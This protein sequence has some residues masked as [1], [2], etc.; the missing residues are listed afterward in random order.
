MNKRFCF[1]CNC[2]SCRREKDRIFGEF[3]ARGQQRKASAASPKKTVRE[4]WEQSAPVGFFRVRPPAFPWTVFEV[5]RGSAGGYYARVHNTKPGESGRLSPLRDEYIRVKR[6]NIEGDRPYWVPCAP[7]MTDLERRRR[8]RDLH[9]DK[10]GRR[11]TPEE[12]VEYTLLAGG[13]A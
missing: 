12:L 4:F 10:L 5:R 6:S 8:L 13:A 3:Q 9:P 11:Q 2:P 7:P 1:N